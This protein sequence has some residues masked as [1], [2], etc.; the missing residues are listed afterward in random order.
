M[1]ANCDDGYDPRGYVSDVEQL[2]P[3]TP[4]DQGGENDAQEGEARHDRGNLAPVGEN[5]Q[6]PPLAVEKCGV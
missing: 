3:E 1:K 4:N 2:V 5:A 6:Q